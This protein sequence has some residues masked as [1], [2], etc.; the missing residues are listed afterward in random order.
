MEWYGVSQKECYG[1]KVECYGVEVECYGLYFLYFIPC[2]NNNHPDFY[3]KVVKGDGYNL[4]SPVLPNPF[5]NTSNINP[6]KPLATA[7]LE[8]T[9]I[10]IFS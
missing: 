2:D 3:H 6:A 9:F 5:I 8:S 10:A 1:A 4:A 7:S